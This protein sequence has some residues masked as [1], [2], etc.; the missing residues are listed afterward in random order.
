MDN[1][2]RI[3]QEEAAVGSLLGTAVGDALG[4]PYEGI[5]RFRLMRMR[6]KVERYHFL[7]G[8]GMLSDDAEHALITAQALI[9]CRGD[10]DSFSRILTRRLKYWLLGLPAGIGTATFK[11]LLKAAFGYKPGDTGVY[12]AGNGP[13]MRAPI[14]GVYCGQDRKLL[15][16]LIFASS[17]ITHTDP[18]AAYGSLAV[19]QAA[20]MATFGH[21]E[22]DDYL[23]EIKELLGEEGTELTALLG[24]AA[25]SANLGQTPFDFALD[26]GCKKGVGGYIYHTVPV[27]I[28][29]WLNHQNDYIKGIQ[30]IIACGDDTD[31]TAAILGGIIGARVGEAGIPGKWIKGI[32]ERPRNVKWMREVG[33][34]VA[35]SA[36]GRIVEP[37]RKARWQILP[38]NFLFFWVLM[39]HMFRRLFPPY[40]FRKKQKKKNNEKAT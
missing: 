21:V 31:T 10:A 18:K 3:G 30:E 39:A 11:A 5:S 36:K 9:E 16:Q 37:V 34:R 27:V 23:R 1:E 25:S 33:L 14:I 6:P 28:Q 8:R 38:R 4:L 7:F 22:S 40:A 29:V 17:R 19:A 15:K 13:A 24:K 26:I 32:W 2:Q 35:S 12:S 20:Y